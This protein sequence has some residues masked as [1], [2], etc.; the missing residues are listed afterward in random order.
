MVTIVGA[1]SI[2]LALGGRLAGSGTPVVFLTRRPEAAH[3]LRARGVT[4]RDPASGDALHASV[5][6][7]T[8]VSALPPDARAGPFLVCVRATDTLAVGARIAEDLPGAWV[9]SAQNDV[10]NE[11][12]LAGLGLR[13]S[14]LVV[15]QTCTV[16]SQVEAFALG[17]GRVVLGDHPGGFG[18]DCG[19]LADRL[20]A[21]GFEVGRSRSIAQ[22]KWLKLC[23]NLMS[24]PNA[25][26]RRPDH[27]TAAFVEAKAR[28]LEE[29]SDV[30]RASGIPAASC[31]GR[32]RSLEDEIRWQRA[33]LE[34]GESARDLP[35]YNAVWRALRDP[36]LG[37]EADRFHGRIVEMGERV[38]VATPVNRRALALV[39]TAVR[40]RRGPESI[41]A[42]ALLA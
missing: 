38:G 1:G 9:V 22:D 19:E 30:L 41:E 34:A 35:L 3:A 6:A 23:V 8:S 12:G 29:A 4:L 15:R 26:V 18:P 5:D 11:A 13:T 36:A 20:E 28:L 14:G 7:A 32:D 33:S 39:R 40:E 2:G 21:A 37:L 24:T 31:D 42:A 16:Q 17:R 27:A 10:D 25:L